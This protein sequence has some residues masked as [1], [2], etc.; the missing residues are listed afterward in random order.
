MVVVLTSAVAQAVPH[1]FALF[2]ARALSPHI[3]NARLLAVVP[4]P[5]VSVAVLAALPPLVPP[6]V[7]AR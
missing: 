4:A 2:R 6:L 1:S 5:L 3:L 7:S